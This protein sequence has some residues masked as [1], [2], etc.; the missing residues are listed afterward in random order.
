MPE[1]SAQA[2][3]KE[4]VPEDTETQELVVELDPIEVSE[5]IEEGSEGSEF[6]IG[7]DLAEDDE[8]QEAAAS[9]AE[10]IAETERVAVADDL[11]VEVVDGVA[12]E[13]ELEVPTPEFQDTEVAMRASAKLEAEADTPVD[14]FGEAQPVATR[15]ARTKANDTVFTASILI[16]IGNKPFLR[17]SSGDLSWQTGIPMDFEEI[18]KWRWVAPADLDGPVEVQ[19]YRNDEDPDRKG[20]HTLEPGQKLEVTPVF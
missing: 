14:L 13:P 16:G 17:G 8:L 6:P 7:A 10:V 1:E 20:R 3:P 18:G 2:V 4:S 11:I 9:E 12:A 19:I 15:R 5:T